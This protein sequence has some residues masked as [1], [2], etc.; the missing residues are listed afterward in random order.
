MPKRI[1]ALAKELQIDSKELVDICTRIGILNKGSALASLEDDE[2]ARISKYISG[3]PAVAP[4][5]PAAPVGPIRAPIVERS[6]PA[7]IFIPSPPAPAS[8]TTAQ[9]TVTLPPLVAPEP[10]VTPQLLLLPIHSRQYAHLSQLPALQLPRLETMN[11]N[12]HHATTLRRNRQADREFVVSMH[13]EQ[14]Q[15]QLLKRT[16]Q[17]PKNAHSSGVNRLSTLPSFLREVNR[18]LHRQN[19]MNPRPNALKSD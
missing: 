4:E 5:K 3:G 13:V 1:Y 16:V 6:A 8:A 19:Q 18:L 12:G 11:R 2:V 17:R 7:E 9:P 14:T 15:A 10:K